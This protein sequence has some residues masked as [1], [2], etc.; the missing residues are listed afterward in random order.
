VEGEYQDFDRLA[1]A[2]VAVFEGFEGIFEELGYDLYYDD[3]DPG[4]P[5]KRWAR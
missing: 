5:K 4:R 3:V 1:K 2:T